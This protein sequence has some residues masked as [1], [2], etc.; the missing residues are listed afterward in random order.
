M[1]LLEKSSEVGISIQQFTTV[2]S[3]PPQHFIP[4]ATQTDALC[5]ISFGAG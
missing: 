3:F 5:D 1:I 2:S 4:H